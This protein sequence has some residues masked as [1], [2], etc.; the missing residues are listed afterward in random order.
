MSK[1]WRAHESER[2]GDDADFGA[3]AANDSTW[4]DA[5]SWRRSEGNGWQN[6][7]ARLPESGMLDFSPPP[8]GSDMAPLRAG[9][10][11]TARSGISVDVV[12]LESLSKGGPQPD[13]I[14]GGD[15]RV[16]ALP[17]PNGA[18]DHVIIA[19]QSGVDGGMTPTQM[20]GL[21]ALVAGLGE[22]SMQIGADAVRVNDPLGLVLPDVKAEAENSP[23]VIPP[24]PPAMDFSPP[25]SSD[26]P[27]S[28][29][30]LH[31][32][33]HHS[34]HGHS[35]RHSS[36]S[37]GGSGGG[38]GFDGGR[39]GSSGWNSGGDGSSSGGNNTAFYN[40]LNDMGLLGDPPDFTKLDQ[41]VKDGKMSQAAA[42][43]LK[44]ELPHLRQSAPGAD[45]SHGKLDVVAG[46]S[47]LAKTIVADAT[48]EAHQLNSHG[49]CMRGVRLA[50]EK[51]GIAQLSGPAA[52]MGANELAKDKDFHEVPK[53]TPLKPGDVVVHG[54]TGKNPYGHILVYLG[55]GME[56]SDHVAPLTNMNYGAW[57]RVFRPV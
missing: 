49:F 7:S 33:P 38:S 14:I 12:P 54:P 3:P 20:Y 10:G 2:A 24:Y 47:S 48:A 37:Q 17:N 40:W 55:N 42:K 34:H 9:V 29:A 22:A 23:L 18:G 52:W 57:T 8:Y 6:G 56:A 50:L 43:Q 26:N 45:S 19:V 28:V 1:H 27:G 31:G 11:D 53:N 46:N 5:A 44:K 36:D 21:N 32:S 13:F 35:A 51:H 16:Q 41:L 30:S 25:A 39:S 15:G 4:R